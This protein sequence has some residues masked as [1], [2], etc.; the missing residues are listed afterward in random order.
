[1]AEHVKFNGGP[2][3]ATEK[4]I[5]RSILKHLREHDVLVTG[6]RIHDHEFGDVEIDAFIIFPDVGIGVI[7]VKGSQ[8]T[9]ADG[10]WWQATPEGKKE[11]DPSGQALR[12]LYSLRRFIER[13]NRWSRGK[14][15]GDWF[16]AFPDTHLKHGEDLGPQGRRETI[17]GKEEHEAVARRIY[18]I[19][20][21][22]GGIPTPAKG[23]NEQLI[24]TL[25]SSQVEVS[26]I[27]ERLAKRIRHSD[28]LTQAQTR[29]L[30]L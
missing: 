26:P 20:A 10:L 2:S 28:Q 24:E 11:I 25:R 6:L 30:D 18:D 14:L 23:W 19:L 16:L 27:E 29:I 22:P 3:T 15:R 21:R 17:F 4:L 1:M 13:Q 8:I 5:A 7:E 9:F 12:G